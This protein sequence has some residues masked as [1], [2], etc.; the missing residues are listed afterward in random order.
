LNHG[1]QLSLQLSPYVCALK[2]ANSPLPT[3]SGP[4]SK[5]TFCPPKVVLYEVLVDFSAALGSL[6]N[7]LTVQ[8]LS[9]LLALDESTLTVNSPTPDASRRN[10]SPVL[11]HYE[12]D[13]VDDQWAEPIPLSP[14]VDFLS[15]F[16]RPSAHD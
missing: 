5:R 11:S 14:S 2:S 6:Q 10:G 13:W 15:C 7:Y 9:N 1:Y 4:T 8:L 3:S 12:F 16:E